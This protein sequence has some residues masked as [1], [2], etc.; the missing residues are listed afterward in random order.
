MKSISLAKSALART[1]LRKANSLHN[2]ATAAAIGFL[3]A[4]AAGQLLIQRAPYCEIIAIDARG[5]RYVSGS[6][7]TC[8]DAADGAELPANWTDIH[9]EFRP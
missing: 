8:L 5:D 6:G 9:V 7:T 3:V 4:L 2:L 1:R